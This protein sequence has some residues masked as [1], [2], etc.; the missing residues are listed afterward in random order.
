VNRRA[1]N[2]KNV[3]TGERERERLDRERRRLARE[4]R[5]EVDNSGNLASKNDEDWDADEE[6]AFCEWLSQNNMD[7]Q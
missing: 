3:L 6:L 7:C 5:M 4:S 2:V 1:K